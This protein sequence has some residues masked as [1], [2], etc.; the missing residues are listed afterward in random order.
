MHWGN[1]HDRAEA[2]RELNGIA[3]VL[4]ALGAF[5]A[6]VAIALDSLKSAKLSRLGQVQVQ[7]ANLRAAHQ[8]NPTYSLT[9][10][11]KL[12][13]DHVADGEAESRRLSRRRGFLSGL[14]LGGASLLF[15]GAAGAV[16]AWV[17]S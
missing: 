5:V 7:L 13:A 2:L 1:V 8:K 10:F 6:A 3:L 15:L 9:E 11:E 17:I 16:W 4:T 14:A 12:E